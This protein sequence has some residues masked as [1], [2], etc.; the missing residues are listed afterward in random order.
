MC[1]C[2]V[3]SSD[4]LLVILA[5]AE[6]TAK[7]S[8]LWGCS[9]LACTS[10]LAG[11][12]LSEPAA[13]EALPLGALRLPRHAAGSTVHQPPGNLRDHLKFPPDVAAA[14]PAAA[15]SV[16]R[17]PNGRE[18]K[19]KKKKNPGSG[20]GGARGGQ[21]EEQLI[22]VSSAASAPRGQERFHANEREKVRVWRA[23]EKEGGG[24]GGDAGAQALTHRPGW[25]QNRSNSSSQAPSRV[26]FPF[27]EGAGCGHQEL[28]LILAVG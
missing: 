20:G 14:S 25:A 11:S 1:V 18:L 15:A 8:G 16:Q 24:G 7:L 26:P 4:P 23:M 9:F 27:R 28:S 5:P 13:A 12:V 10:A 3:Y 6:S 2:N 21:G 17:C 19:K 22:N